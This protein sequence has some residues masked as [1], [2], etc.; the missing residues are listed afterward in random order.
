MKAFAV[1]IYL[2]TMLVSIFSC[3]PNNASS[4]STS[5]NEEE[6]ADLSGPTIYKVAFRTGCEKPAAT[7]AKVYIQ[8]Y[9]SKGNSPES[10]MDH[11]SDNEFESCS[12]DEFNLSV[13]NHLGTLDSLRVWHDNSGE[14]PDWKVEIITIIETKSGVRTDWPCGKWFATNRDNGVTS[15][16]FYTHRECK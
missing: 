14:E 6:S 8:L 1:S 11:P 15:R 10:L 4:S 16:M 9:G 13:D 12:R 7:N 5:Q 3:Q 2:F